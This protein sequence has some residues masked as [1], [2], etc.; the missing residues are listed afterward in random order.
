[1]A[2]EGE[3]DVF[4]VERARNGAHILGICV[5]MWVIGKSGLE[6]GE[7]EGLDIDNVA[8]PLTD[9][10]NSQIRLPNVGWLKLDFD[11]EKSVTILSS[12]KK[13]N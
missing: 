9:F 13:N 12:K 2:L 7:H 5:G 3:L 11:Y 4:L 1:M 6:F 10:S 8:Q